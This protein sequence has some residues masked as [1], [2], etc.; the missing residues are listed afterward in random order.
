M[1][2]YN[3]NLIFVEGEIDKVFIDFI[4]LKYFQ[5]IDSNLVIVVNGKDNLSK[6]IELKNV[7]RKENKA[8]NLLIFDTDFKEKGGG[9]K[10][11]LSEYQSIA[12]EL[13]VDF[14]IFLLPF[15]DGTE[16]EIED[17]IK[18]CF[19]NEF[20]A[21]DKC[22]DKMIACFDDSSFEKPLNKPAKEGFL[23]SKIDL[24]KNYRQS[25]NWNYGKLTKYDY[26]DQGIW[27]LDINCNPKLERL[28]NFIKDNLFNDK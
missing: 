22:W 20:D 2:N 11:R 16:G 12:S 24:F 7:L 10:Q 25:S 8:K 13:S 4:L 27:D 28:I 26:N 19:R 14:Q 9:S 21:F 1:N 15:N 5:I 23:F 17:L 6:Q 3:L 18:T